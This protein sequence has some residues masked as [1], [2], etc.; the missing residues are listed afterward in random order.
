MRKYAVLVACVALC[1][2]AGCKKQKETGND[3]QAEPAAKTTEPSPPAPATAP[4]AQPE[5]P[6]AASAQDKVEFYQ[7]CIAALNARD[8]DKFGGCYAEDTETNFVD[9]EDGQLKGRADTVDKGSKVMADAFPD[10]KVTPQ[11]ILQSG[12]KIAAITFLSG[13]QTKPLKAS[14]GELPPTNKKVGLYSLHLVQ[15]ASDKLEVAK[16]WSVMDEASFAGQLGLI[17]APHRPAEAKGF[18]DKPT[19]VTGDPEGAAE[20]A[21]A[22][23]YK[24]ALDGLEKHDFKAWL[25]LLAD[26]AV[27]HDA[28]MPGESN[29]KKSEAFAKEVAK[30]FPDGK[31]EPVDVWAAGDYVVAVSRHT[32]TN[33]GPMPSMHIKKPTNKPVSFTRANIMRFENGK[34]VESW[35]FWNSGS[36]AQQLGLGS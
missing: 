14:G 16:S 35:S 34:V 26:S 6:K 25:D 21:N 8:W 22:V 12:D 32:G 36:V 24:K 5:Q 18:A 1:L 15:L 28:A 7:G 29:K 4:A 19:V 27:L 2:A 9:A 33:K 23:A 20:K 3:T 31:V 17:E 11:V 30:G 13:T 10:I